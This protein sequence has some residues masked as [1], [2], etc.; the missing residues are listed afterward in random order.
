VSREV[1]YTEGLFCVVYLD[2]VTFGNWIWHRPL[3][4]VFDIF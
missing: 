2:N 4:R 1:K 3:G